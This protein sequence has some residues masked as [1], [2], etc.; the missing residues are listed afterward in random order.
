M[1]SWTPNSPN[2]QHPQYVLIWYSAMSLKRGQFS[3]KN[4]Q[5]RHPTAHS[6]VRGMGCLLC[7]QHVVD[8]LPQFL[9]LSMQYLT[10]L[11]RVMTVFYILLNSVAQLALMAHVVYKNRTNCHTQN[12]RKVAGYFKWLGLS[13]P[14]EPWKNSRYS[15]FQSFKEGWG[16]ANV[17][18]R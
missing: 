2:S 6:L 5:K 13:Y 15:E 12:P 11:D 8:V 10:I 4:T 17:C 1:K 14:L 7:I 3:K 9:Q 18:V 16:V